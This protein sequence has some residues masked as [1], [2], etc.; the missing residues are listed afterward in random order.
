[1]QLFSMGYPSLPEGGPCK[2]HYLTP[3]YLANYPPIPDVE[4]RRR[5]R[6]VEHEDMIKTHLPMYIVT[7]FAATESLE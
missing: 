2:K 4:G 5:R 1:M 6:L 3:H 7:V